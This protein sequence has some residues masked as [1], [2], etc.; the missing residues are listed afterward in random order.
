LTKI[1]ENK[2]AETEKAVALRNALTHQIQV[3]RELARDEERAKLQHELKSMTELMKE[4]EAIKV[5]RF[6]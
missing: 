6:L 3:E 2:R 4:N 5:V 1:I